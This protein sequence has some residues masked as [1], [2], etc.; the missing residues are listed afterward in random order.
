MSADDSFEGRIRAIAEQ[1][2]K[3]LAG[4]VD[5]FAERLGVDPDRARAA[6]SNLER[7]L[8]DRL[9]GQES[10][11]S[12]DQHVSD[13]ARRTTPAT[14]SGSGPHPLDL[15]TP[16]QGLALSGPRHKFRRDHAAIAAG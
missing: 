7:W 15:P 11:T 5:E 4:D 14:T 10:G 3:S 9:S 12:D 8:S 13:T 16:E 2:A 6:A 1:I